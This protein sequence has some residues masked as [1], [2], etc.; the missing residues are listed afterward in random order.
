MNLK[1]IISVGLLILSL[2]PCFT[3]TVKSNFNGYGNTSAVTGM[4]PTYT[5]SVVGF[6]GSFRSL[7]DGPWLVTNV[8]VGDVIWYDCTRFVITAVNS[9]GGSAFNVDVEVP[10]ED[11]AIGV[12]T[13]LNNQRVAVVRELPGTLPAFPPTADGNAGALA[14]IT[15]SL[16]SCML[17]HYVQQINTQMLDADEVACVSGSGAPNNSVATTDG[18][19]L[20]IN[21]GCNVSTGV[22][23]LW[24]GTSWVTVSSLGGSTNTYSVV[25]STGSVSASTKQVNVTTLSGNIT[26]T[27]PT[28]NVTND[29]VNIMFIKSGTDNYSTI[30]TGN[31]G[32]LFIDGQANKLLYS[33]SNS[34]ECT[35][36][37]NTGAWFF[38]H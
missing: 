12:S 34:F 21:N 19:R 17:T 7:L 24:N 36:N 20:A 16:F 28:C 5:M 37:G 10:A 15:G 13:P 8:M 3:Q 18:Y 27:L 35:C 38:T 31:G 9:A 2:T 4:G 29:G 32:Q 1:H 22:L 30:I 23:Y 33:T 6:V 26:L 14:G 25:N 11:W